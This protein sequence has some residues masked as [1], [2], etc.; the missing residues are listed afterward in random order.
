MA[1][2]RTLRGFVNTWECDENDHLN[3]QFYF[4]FFEDACG[5]FQVMA[6]VAAAQQREPTLRHVRYHAELRVNDAVEVHTIGGGDTGQ[7]VVH[8]LSETSS[9]RL[10]ATC[11]ETYAD[12]PEALAAALRNHG[13]EVPETALPRS[14]DP[15][16]VLPGP[17]G[18]RP[19]GGRMVLGARIRAGQCRPDGSVFDSAIIGLNSDSA[20]HFWDAV[21]IDRAYLKKRR[22]GRVAVEMK[23][24]RCGPL[25]FGDLVHVVTRPIGV[26]RSTVT[27]ENRFVQSASGEVA[28]I[29]QVTGLTMNLDTRRAEPL[30]A[31]LKARIEADIAGD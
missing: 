23:L 12:P 22:L 31:D 30:S 29:V 28:A 27:F 8:L 21:G 16:P 4:R 17:E 5:H 25:A 20:A 10:S 19:R 2:L 6:G 15:A 26:A 14:V 1:P 9:G 18:A 24:T 7:Q 3:V 11:L 13:G